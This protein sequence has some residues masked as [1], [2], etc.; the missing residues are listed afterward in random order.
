LKQLDKLNE[1]ETIKV[2]LIYVANQQE[3][4]KDILRNDESSGSKIYKE[5][6]QSLGWDV[7][8]RTHGGFMG[9]LDENLT[10]GTTAPYYSNATTEVIFHDITRMPTKQNDSQQIQKKR[11]VGN[12][13]VHIVWSEHDRDYKPWTISSQFN[14]VHICIYPWQRHKESFL[15]K[16]GIYTKPEVP[17]FGPLVDGMIVDKKDL[18]PLVRMTA[19]NANKA[20]RYKQKQYK[21]P[22][23]TRRSHIN[24][25]IQRHKAQSTSNIDFIKTFFLDQDY[26][27]VEFTPR[28][29]LSPITISQPEQTTIQS[30]EKP[31]QEV[32]LRNQ[33][34]R[35]S[36]AK[37][38][39]QQETKPEP[40]KVTQ[41]AVEY[42]EEVVEELVDGE[43]E[44][45]VEY[46]EEVV[47]VD[48]N[49]QPIT[50]EEGDE[51][52]YVE[53]EEEEYQ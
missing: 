2:G 15:F 49:G 26:V 31:Q 25:I 24:E 30:S 1:R 11:H 12:D 10:T 36:V 38:Q 52:E 40:Q 32:R 16:I 3:Q 14:F 27:N 37:V 51:V 45:G 7:D 42:V 19:I 8:L 29:A 35:K 47:Y 18:G 48:E 39:P 41:P 23:P 5:F 13:F 20:V 21:K 34:I 46:V 50:I 9:G 44:E 17:L 4:Q 33:S 22:F 43:G 6:V 28:K 53:V